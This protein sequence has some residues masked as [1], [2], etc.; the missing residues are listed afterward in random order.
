LRKKVSG[1]ILNK[2]FLFDQRI[3]MEIYSK[4]KGVG[5][6][7]PEKII[8]NFDLEEIVDTTNEWIIQRTGIKKRRIADNNIATSDLAYK[9]ALKAMEDASVNPEEIDAIIIGTATPD[10]M[11]PSTACLVQDKIK[12][13]NAFAFDINAGCTG[14]IYGLYIADSFIKSG[15]CKTCLVIGAEIISKFLNWSDRTSCVLFGDGA[16]AVILKADKEP[17]IRRVLLGSD[18]SYSQLLYMPAGGS[19]MPATEETVENNLHTVH[20]KGREVFKIAV[21]KLSSLGEKILKKLN[22]D[23]S[24]LDLFVPHQAN[25]R[26]IESV[27]NKL[28]LKENQIFVNIHNYG[29]TSAASIPIAL[30]EAIKNGDIT[31]GLKVLIT[32]FGAGLTWGGALIEF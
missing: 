1:G 23:I 2:K 21:N 14:F 24:M 28:G 7:T 15:K 11:F 26:I 4:I 17:G 20:M 3:F 19:R 6:Y 32:A 25:K 9:A 31:R 13:K 27:A 12:A 5:S 16:G 18:G 22:I 30:D 8:T 29:N 10:H